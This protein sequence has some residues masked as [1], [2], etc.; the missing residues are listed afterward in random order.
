MTRKRVSAKKRPLQSRSSRGSRAGA[1]PA[2]G[3]KQGLDDL[4]CILALLRARAKFDFGPYKKRALLRRIERRMGLARITRLADY[5]NLLR[6]DAAE[7]DALCKDLRIRVT[8]FFREPE[9]WRFLEREVVAPLVAAKPAGSPLRIWVPGCAT[10]EEAYSIAM[11]VMEQLHAMHKSCPI[12]IFATDV[13]RFALQAARAGIY[14]E[15]IAADVSTDRLHRFFTPQDHG[16]RITKEVRQTVVFAEHNLITDPPFP[17]LDLIRCCN[18]LMYLEPAVQARLV[19]CLHFALVDGG[20]LVLGRAEGIGQRHDLFTMVSKKWRIHRRIGPQRPGEVP[21]PVVTGS[22]A[23]AAHDP[24]SVGIASVDRNS[25]PDLAQQRLLERF[26]PASVVVSRT[27]QGADEELKV[28]NEELLSMN[29]ELQSTNE[30]LELSTSELQA[31][32]E[33][34]DTRLAELRKAHSDLQAEMAARQCAQRAL[35]ES[36]ER[37]R[38]LLRGVKDYAIVMLD[39]GGRVI[40]WNPGA[41]RIKGYTAEE[42]LG[43]HF[44]SFYLSEDVAAGKPERALRVAATTGRY[45]EEGWRVR[46]NGSRF[47]ASIL[48]SPVRDE[49]GQPR[50]F[51]K[52][53]RDIT[54]RKEAERRLSDLS[55]RLLTSQEEERRR[56]GRELH[57]GVSQSLAAAAMSLAHVQRAADLLSA[58]AQSALVESLNLIDQTA[59]EIRTLSYLLHPPLLDDVGLL[60]AMRW[61]AEGFAKRSGIA[62]ELD[63]PPDLARLPREIEIALFRVVQESLTNVHRHSGSPTVRIQLRRPD[64]EITLRVEDHGRGMPEELQRAGGKGLHAGVGIMGMRERVHQFGGRFDIDSRPGGT[65]VVAT[66]PLAAP[67]PPTASPGE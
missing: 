34:L 15:S 13:D 59:R 16:Y 25:L 28:A 42:I 67:A 58:P 52:V 11:V 36:E 7:V 26:A 62:V 49:S 23:G 41:E 14:P 45:E 29:E 4:D 56:I 17:R 46:K 31:V 57:D 51:A 35:Q 5:L 33:E 6:T 37:F 66:L 40:S 38:L 10:G 53:T 19:P 32:N 43:K 3:L 20:Y 21:F 2:A 12:Q 22:G 30:E 63:A 27:H 1:V 65:V 47:F 64:G 60:S 61:Y 8:S 55:Q 9:S 18:L 44:S 24:R 50:G 48:I 54:E 39:P